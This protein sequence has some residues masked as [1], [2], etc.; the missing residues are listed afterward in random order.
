MHTAT[1]PFR[2][3]FLA[4]LTALALA[5][6]PAALGQVTELEPNDSPGNSN[7]FVV[8]DT[9]LGSSCAEPDWFRFTLPAEGQL[10]LW[11]EAINPTG[12]AANFEVLAFR[13][14]GGGTAP[15]AQIGSANANVPLATP[16]YLTFASECN[17]AGQYWLRLTSSG[18]CINYRVKVNFNPIP[19]PNEAEPN[20][21]PDFASLVAMGDT[22]RGAIM[23]TNSGTDGF[24]WWQLPTTPNATLQV[25]FAVN[26]TSSTSNTYAFVLF[27]GDGIT[28]ASSFNNL[29]V[30]AGTSAAQTFSFPCIA[31]GVVYLRV[32]GTGCGTYKLCGSLAD[33]VPVTESEPNDVYGQAALLAEADTAKGQIEYA[34][35]AVDVVD[36]WRGDLVGN[37]SVE[38]YFEATNTSGALATYDFVVYRGDGITGASGFNNL[39]SVPAG[40]TAAQTFRFDCFAPGDFYLRV[41]SANGCGSYKL[42][43][44]LVNTAPNAEQP[45]NNSFATAQPLTLDTWT[46]GHIQYVNTTGASD[47]NDWY[48]VQIPD[49]VRVKVLVTTTST[50]AGPGVLVLDGF[51][52]AQ[53]LVGSR[54]VSSAY[55]QTV[56][57]SLVV[58]CF[59]HQSF[60]LRIQSNAVCMQY[61]IKVVA[62]P[63]VPTASF[64][65]SRYGNTIG[66]SPDLANTTAFQWTLGDGTTSNR[67]FPIHTFAF[68]NYTTTLVATNAT[69]NYTSTTAQYFELSGLETYVPPRGGQGAVQMQ[70]Y[71]G[72]MT[73]S[74]VVRLVGP[75]GTYTATSGYANLTN[76]VL[77]AQFDLTT[78]LTGVYDLEVDI[79]GNGTVTVADGFTVEGF[80]YPECRTELA[81][82]SR[83]LAN[84]PTTFRLSVRNLGNVT[85]DGVVV[86]LAWPAGVTMQLGA[87]FGQPPAGGTTDVVVDGTTYTL[88][89]DALITYNNVVPVSPIAQLNGQPYNG[90]FTTFTVPHVAPFGA[91]EIPVTFTS[92]VTGLFNVYS[93]AAPLNLYLAGQIT[94]NWV[95][96]LESD[97]YEMF[98]F[99]DF[100]DGNQNVPQGELDLGGKVATGKVEK[101]GTENDDEWY[102]G[103]N[104]TGP[105]TNG[106]PPIVLDNLPGEFEGAAAAAAEAIGGQLSL[107]A[108]T[109]TQPNLLQSA[110]QRIDAR[111]K[112]TAENSQV[113]QQVVMPAPFFG[114]T[115]IGENNLQLLNKLFGPDQDL[116]TEDDLQD[117]NEQIMDQRNTPQ[118]WRQYLRKLNPWLLW[119]NILKT[120]IFNPVGSWDPN[121]IVGPQGV[122]VPG[123]IRGNELQP[124]IVY[125]ENVDTATAAAQVVR[126]V[127]T[128]DVTK[129]DATTFTFGSVIVGST[130]LN[131]PPGRQEFVLDVQ[132]QPG[133]PFKVRVN[134]RFDPASGIATW[135]FITLD[136]NT[137]NLP[138]L[139]GFLPPNVSSPEGEGS[140]SY[141]VRPLSGLPSNSTLASRATIFFD[142]NEPIVTNTWVN[143]T[144]DV[145]PTSF[146]SASVQVE[147]ITLTFNGTDD[148]S[149]IELYTVYAS[150]N[151]APYRPLAASAGNVVQVTGTIGDT[152]AFYCEAMDRVGNREVKASI[153]EATVTITGVAEHAV[154]ELFFT[155]WPNP[156]DG[157]ITIMAQRPIRGA[158]LL[159]TDARGRSVLEERLNLD[160]TGT[161]SLDLRALGAGTYTIS[162]RSPSGAFGAQRV[163]VVR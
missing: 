150:R 3:T 99:T 8:A 45:G 163:V 43:Y 46:D 16:T 61:R 142:L 25:H 108:T 53:V 83:F 4:S 124:F 27:F 2:L 93:Y 153:A 36:W 22:A 97:V 134:G 74:T 118:N 132:L 113:N 126:V 72:S 112:I 66:Y 160:A 152:W 128:L 6:P 123:Y 56:Q 76:S 104:S 58:D 47:V 148:A 71:G 122:D 131:V 84:R 127:D 85:A 19:A 125:F 15:A 107:E 136:P 140:V 75:G 86:G 11:V 129:F 95:N 117:K 40:A 35:P 98:T 156:S 144:D 110:K 151:G 63:R 154:E 90:F 157:M 101:A 77:T 121:A 42:S 26:N 146:V 116:D 145:P 20:N 50:T 9:V 137:N 115:E 147:T 57:D 33:V 62:E 111:H 138:V 135:E 5:A 92:S 143:T 106:Q 119:K 91:V 114:S 81:G 87:F 54:S 141:N 105:T 14:D 79:P 130:Y 68:G 29:S 82:P 60:H 67:Q 10:D 48:A 31:A 55:L 49:S 17:A 64:A 52:P 89:N 37:G 120:F 65:R 100:Y 39:S 103:Q 59:N 44:R 155:T 32:E 23:Y 1:Y 51:D 28:Q 133:D 94:P 13:S 73:N 109:M 7:P 139:D 30:P 96:V 162:L 161:Y 34:N 41:E 21:G 12:P 69:C 102:E 78:A 18:V 158:T 88:D 80:E 24:D 149:G 38:V 70:L 159:V